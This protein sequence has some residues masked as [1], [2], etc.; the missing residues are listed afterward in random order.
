MKATRMTSIIFQKRVVVS[1]IPSAGFKK[2]KIEIKAHPTIVLS[3][4]HS[5]Y[6]DDRHN[7]DNRWRCY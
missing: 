7:D 2:R 1:T 3:D 4:L 6:V 5:P